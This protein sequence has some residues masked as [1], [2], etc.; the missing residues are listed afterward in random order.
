MRKTVIVTTLFILMVMATMPVMAGSDV[1]V[2]AQVRARMQ[3]VDNTLLEEMPTHH[4]SELRAR[5]GIGATV[6]DNA[7]LY[8]QFQDSR[9]A[10]ADAGTSGGLSGTNVVDMH[11]GYIKIDKIF[12]EG[13]GGMAGRFEFAKGNQRFFG[14]VGWHQVGRAWDGCAMWYA[15][16][17]MNVTGFWLNVVEQMDP[18]FN[19][20]TDAYG[21]YATL[22]KVNLDLFALYEVDSDTTKYES[23]ATTKPLKRYN[24]GMYYKRQMDQFDVEMNAVLQSGTQGANGVYQGDADEY[25]ISAFMFTF[26]G[27]MTFQDSELKPRVAVGIDY[28]SGDDDFT[29]E[30]VSTFTNA[31]YTGHKFRGYMDYFLGSHE[32]GLIDLMF[33]GKINPAPGWTIKGDFHHFTTA[34]EYDISGTETSKDV[35]MEF[36]FTVITSKVPGVKLALGASIFMPTENWEGFE[37]PE[38]GFWAYTQAIVNVK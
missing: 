19:S 32:Y 33:R 30:K 34:K 21:I 36:D 8:I 2:D 22:K 7:H 28:S 25:D 14:S 17:N 38:K 26:E 9:V 16:E 12:G 11:Q 15:N 31:Y 35:G 23:G 37:D 27:G 10:G 24:F 29:D 4:F 3:F 20:D 13:W 5:L 18:E 6:E 1:K